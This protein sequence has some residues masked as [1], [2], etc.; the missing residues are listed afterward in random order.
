M[1]IAYFHCFSGIS[2]DMTL[3]AML[4]AGLEL[5]QLETDL[6]KLNLTGY[7][8][9][10]EK[11]VKNGIGGTK[12]HVLVEE[13]PTHRHLH[14]ITDI[15]TNSTLPDVVKSKSIEIFSRLAEAEAKVH[16]T[17]PDKI[18]FHEVGALDAII[19]VVGAVIGF[20][21]L[22]IEEVYASPL[23]T[24]SGFTHCA[25][26]VIPVP[27]PAVLELLQGVPVY[28]KDADYELVT[29]TGAAI[30]STYCASFGNIPPMKVINTGYGAGERD[31]V[32]PNLLRLT[33]GEKIA[34]GGNNNGNFDSS[35]D[36]RAEEALM[37]EANIDDMNPEFYD[38]LLTR[39]LDAGAMDVC[40]RNIQMKKNRPGVVVSVLMQPH[41]LEQFYS[42]I[43]AETTSIGVRVYP[44]T[45]Y[46][47]S[48]EIV[49]IETEFG[50]AR[51]KL[52]RDGK[53]LRNVAP[54][55][56][57]C[58]RLAEERGIPLKTVYDTVKYA[59]ERKLQE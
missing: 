57:D 56:E 13:E 51:V 46:M 47:L 32:L 37:M 34:L 26:G 9:K 45:K 10:T 25:H 58:R 41:Q 6:A 30:I 19:D 24:G 11:V 43:F 23:N 22:G 4:D 2:G 42:L 54:E 33:I 3:G 50:S 48:R 44:V 5:G 1:K 49:T 31:L 28:A 16:Q 21:R 36:V 52:A 39:L 18:H 53:G 38:Y 12:V 15:I 35:G 17:T 27:A 7:H 55:Y 20:W 14:Y 29:P 59:A 40:L 8:L